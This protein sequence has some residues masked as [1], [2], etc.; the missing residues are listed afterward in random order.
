MDGG[1]VT[2]QSGRGSG[3]ELAARAV[4]GRWQ[5]EM[6]TAAQ[7]RFQ[8]REAGFNMTNGENRP[9]I[10]AGKALIHG[11][12]AAVGVGIAGGLVGCNDPYSKRRIEMRTTHQSEFFEGVEASEQVRARRLRESGETLKVWWARDC[13]DYRRRMPTV[14]DY[15]W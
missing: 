14:G 13:E 15:F 5:W 12:W 8:H 7:P 6:A 9:P 1:G 11:V 3:V 4:L 10:R 2:E